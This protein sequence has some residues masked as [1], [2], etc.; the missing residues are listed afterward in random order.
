VSETAQSNH[1]KLLEEA[2]GTAA[3]TELRENVGI[4]AVMASVN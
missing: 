2:P 1:Q 3:M 4:A